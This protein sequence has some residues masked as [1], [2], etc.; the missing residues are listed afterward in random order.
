MGYR[1]GVDVGGTFTDLL[2]LDDSTGAFWRHKTPSTP[3][4]SSEGILN[5]LEAL[6]AETGGSPSDIEVFLHGTTVATNAVL[7]GKGARVGLITTEGYRQIM[8]IAR[9]FVPG[10]LAG[11]IVWPKPEPL[12]KLED[13]VEIKGRMDARGQEVRPLDE[14]DIRTQVERLKVRGVEA[15]T[16]SLINAY[17]NGAHERR[18]GEIIREIM[19]EVPLSLSHEVLPEMQEYERTLTTV[20]NAAVRPVVGRYVRNLRGR[21]EGLNMT[22]SLSLLR[23]DG[24]L[25][26]AAKSEEHPVS[27]LMSG[28]AGGVTGALWVAK[29]AG[30]DNILTLDVGG[31]STDVALIE[32]GEPRRIRTTEVGHLSVRASSLDVKTVGAGGGS[33]AYVPELTRALRVGPQ[34]A[35][36]VPGPVAYGKGGVE[37]TVTDANVVLGYLPEDLL[38]GAFKLDRKGA[39]MAVQTIAD[40]L[41]IGLM[42]AARGI[43]DIVN[44]NMFGALRMISVQQGYDPRSFALMGFGGAGPLHV[45][46]VARLMGSYPA[47]SP[48]SPGVLCALGDATT[49]MR[50]ETARSLSK[51][52]SETSLGEVQR[53][54]AEMEA[55]VRAELAADGVSATDVEPAFEIDVR[56]SGQAFEVPMTVTAADLISGGLAAL[57]QRFDDEHRRLFTFNMDTEHELVNLRATAMGGVVELPSQE[58]A[59]GDGDPSQAKVR[60]HT[61][62]MDGA[63]QPAVIYDRARLEAGDVIPGPAIVVEMDS[64]TLIETR[65]QG[66]VDVHGNILITPV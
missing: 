38:G 45:N 25:M 16:V 14:A 52:L 57:T 51:R 15:L 24:G 29:N 58:L 39:E 54:L 42:E 34:S 36:A 20:A 1:L 5:G 65:H 53:L 48:V 2:L 12:A 59:K 47:V 10:G 62:W 26:S 22:G 56:Y 4:D 13:T 61:L 23:S 46:A 49:R 33:I 28:P 17:L 35:G 27:L 8:Q 11:W 3:H 19:P 66:L 43:I 18:V 64:T 6:C 60:D 37:P 40:K 50:T 30:L 63:A 7:E 55:Q 44:E 9:S 21:L 41:G 32:H 31:T